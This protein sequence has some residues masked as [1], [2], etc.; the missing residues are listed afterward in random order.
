MVFSLLLFYACFL[1]IRSANTAPIMIITMMI[2]TIPYS[3]AV[4]VA[5]PLSGVAVGAAVADA[6][7]AVKLVVSDD[8]Q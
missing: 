3:S 2:A 4:C 6:C 7:I 5:T 8:G 1:I